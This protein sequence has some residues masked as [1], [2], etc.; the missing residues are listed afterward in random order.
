M[1]SQTNFLGMEFPIRAGANSLISCLQDKTIL[2]SGGVE[3]LSRESVLCVYYILIQLVC[4]S[5]A[6]NMAEKLSHYTL[7]G[8]NKLLVYQN[9]RDM[10]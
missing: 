4:G 2:A 8:E 7:V 3:I 6:L 5:T 10:T 9:Y 1:K